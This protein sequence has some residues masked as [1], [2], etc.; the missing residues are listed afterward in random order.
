M[1]TQVILFCVLVLPF[2]LAMISTELPNSAIAGG[3]VVTVECGDVG[4]LVCASEVPQETCLPSQKWLNSA[5]DPTDDDF[6]VSDAL[7]T[8]LDKNPGTSCKG[9]GNGPTRD[10]VNCVIDP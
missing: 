3:Q 9:A 5:A 7:N 2:L 6:Y 10:V 4:E 8:C 1:K